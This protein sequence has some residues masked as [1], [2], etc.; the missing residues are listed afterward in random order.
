MIAFAVLGAAISGAQ[1]A[2]PPHGGGDLNPNLETN[3]EAIA[4]W[5]NARVGF[6]VHWTPVGWRGTEVSWSRGAQVGLKDYD[7]LFKDFNP[8]LF[9][10]KEWVELIKDSGFRYFIPVAK[11]VDGFSMWATKQSDYN[12]SNTPFHRDYL[13]ELSD[14]CHRQGIM[15]GT[16]YSIGDWY[17]YDYSPSDTNRPSGGGPGFTLSRP[18]DFNRYVDYM[19]RQLKELVKDYGSEI[20]LLDGDYSPPYDHERAG[21]LYRYLRGLRS[22]I[23]INNRAEVWEEGSEARGKYTVPDTPPLWMWNPTPFW[24]YSKYAGD[25]QE[26]EEYIGGPAPYPWEAWITLGTQWSWKANDKYKSAEDVIRYLVVTVGSGGNFNLNVTPMPDGRFEQRQK[27][28]LLKV[29]AWL[30]TNGESIYGTQRGPFEPGLW[31]AST[32]RAD[33]V[34]VHVLA[35][36]AVMLQLFPLSREVKSAKRFNG[37][38]VRWK[39][40]EN[41]IEISVAEGERDSLDT[42]VELTMAE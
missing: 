8:V 21:D 7:S 37:E 2:S 3:P 11:H 15:F 18:P 12:I 35:W 19:K 24:N 32:Q 40:I 20:V 1:N 9:N 31:G 38:E 27:D 17:Q 26:R 16:Y 25:Y 36:P 34:Y 10:A 4:K 33:K 14:E 23:V 42:I 22:D 5:E 29:G 41:G 28:T 39:Q 30:K 6:T 13:R